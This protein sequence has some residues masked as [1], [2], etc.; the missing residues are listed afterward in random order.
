MQVRRQVKM[1]P[2]TETCYNVLRCRN[3]GLIDN[4]QG[5][6]FTPEAINCKNLGDFP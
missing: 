5:V 6:V 3:P 1:N 4:I 2:I